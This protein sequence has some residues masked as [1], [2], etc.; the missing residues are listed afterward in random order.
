[1]SVLRYVGKTCE[2]VGPSQTTTL[3]V[4]D[5]IDVGLTY[6]D[7]RVSHISESFSLRWWYCIPRMQVRIVAIDW[8]LGVSTKDVSWEKSTILST[9]NI[10]HL[11]LPVYSP[12]DLSCEHWKSH[13]GT[14]S[15]QTDRL[16]EPDGDA[17]RNP[18]CSR[19]FSP[20]IAELRG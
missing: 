19:L 11:N 7:H 4:E 20:S 10:Q 17:A 1:M 16:R 8:N 12:T 3:S 2:V 18:H 9:A 13:R 6:T 15:M 14:I 5:V